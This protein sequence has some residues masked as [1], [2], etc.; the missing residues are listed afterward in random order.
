MTAPIYQVDA[1]TKNTF[2][3]NPAAVVPLG[4][5][6]SDGILQNIAAENNLS[7]TAFFLV[8]GQ[9]F[10]IRWFTPKMEIDLCGHAT[11]ATAHILFKHLHF[12]RDVILF[13]TIHHG[14][15]KA[16]RH[17]DMIYLEFPST[18]PR[19]ID[20]PDDL[21]KG[22]G[23]VPE[24]ALEARDILA[25]FSKE[26]DI[27]NLDPDFNTLKKLPNLG[28]IATAPG[29]NADFVSRFFAPNAGIDEDPVTGSAHTA[30]IPYWAKRYNKNNLIAY[31]LSHRIGELNCELREDKVLIGG[32]ATTYMKGEIFY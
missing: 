14:V 12:K 30:L 10:E 26:E 29:N 15:L 1:F 3:G 4:H 31:Q 22:L 28:V 2:G 9:F 8:K 13:K 7:E 5:W 20:I 24:E 23:A 32:S 11:L 16:L 19:K 6:P 17:K 21:I 27:V 25:V 18:P